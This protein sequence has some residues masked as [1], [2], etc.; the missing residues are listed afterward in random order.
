MTEN[1][2]HEWLLVYMR[3]S[4]LVAMQHL[5]MNVSFAHR[6]VYNLYTLIH[7]IYA[8]AYTTVITF[9]H[10]ANKTGAING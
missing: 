9:S 8:V 6:L 3:C 2:I 7:V 10:D 1:L 5:A 4:R